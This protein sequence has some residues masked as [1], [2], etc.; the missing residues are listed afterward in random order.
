MFRNINDLELFDWD[1]NVQGL[2]LPEWRLIVM[3]VVVLL[4][5]VNPMTLTIEITNKNIRI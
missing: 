1:P 4:L 2:E 5:R 3:D